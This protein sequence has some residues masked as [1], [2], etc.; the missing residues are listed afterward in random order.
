MSAIGKSMRPAPL[1]WARRQNEKEQ[2]GEE[3]R[4]EIISLRRQ[5]L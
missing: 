5:I 2:G 3:G 1:L 4:K